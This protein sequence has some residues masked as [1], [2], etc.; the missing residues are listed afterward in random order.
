MLRI[1]MGPANSGKSARVLEEIRRL[2][3]GSYQ[4]LQNFTLLYLI[5]HLAGC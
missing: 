3:D 5:S 2:G 4:L 1:W